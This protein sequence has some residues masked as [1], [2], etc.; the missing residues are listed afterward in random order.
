MNHNAGEQFSQKGAKNR[1]IGMFTTSP[2]MKYQGNNVN[3]L[4]ART[5]ARVSVSSLSESSYIELDTHADTSLAGANCKVIAY[6]EQM[7]EVSPYHPK[8]EG[9]KNVPIVQAGT[10]YDHPESGESY[11]LILNQALYLGDQFPIMFLNP[12]Q[13]R[14]NQIIVDDIPR[15]L[16]PDPKTAT[17]SIYFPDDNIRIPLELNGIISRLTTCLPTQKELET[18][19]WLE[20]TADSEWNPH[21]NHYAEQEKLLDEQQPPLP[22]KHEIYSYHSCREYDTAPNEFYIALTQSLQIT[23]TNTSTCYFHT[24]KEELA[25]ILNVGL[26]TAEKTLAATTQLAICN[27]VKPLHRRFHTDIAQL[28]YP[29]LGGHHGIFH[30]DTFFAPCY[31]LHGHIMGQLYVNDI[32]FVKF[33]PMEKK[34]DAPD[35]LVEFCQDIGIP[36][37]LHS[38]N[39]NELTKGRWGELTK[40]YQI[41]VTMSEPYSPWQVHA[42]LTIC[43]V[44]VK[45][46]VRNLRAKVDEHVHLLDYCTTYICELRCLTVYDHFSL[47][48]CTPYEI[49][50]G[51]T[52]DISEYLDYKWYDVIW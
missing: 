6:T 2:R 3:D 48:D 50:T 49:V 33:I 9:I 18:C 31:S 42:E 22:L 41:K 32:D 11:I 27:A 21:S 23:A 37:K 36:S 51:H 14:A 44:K 4:I 13:A 46:A 34:S 20:L 28:W 19:K 40:K 8:D 15:C 39:A 12:N 43:E 26:K 29:R 35:T 30:T 45:Q 17:H 52:P 38:D 24:K 47:H 10:A 1:N 5:I 7:V 25:T 16:V